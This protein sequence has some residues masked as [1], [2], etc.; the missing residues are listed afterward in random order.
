[1]R[2]HEM[3]LMRFLGADSRHTLIHSHTDKHSLTITQERRVPPALALAR[4]VYEGRSAER[5]PAKLEQY[6]EAP[7]GRAAQRMENFA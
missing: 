7:H 4:K 2:D 5:M 1:M 3:M 6:F